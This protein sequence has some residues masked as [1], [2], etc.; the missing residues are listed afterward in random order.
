MTGNNPSDATVSEAI[1][2]NRD[3]ARLA[4]WKAIEAITIGNKW[5]DKLI[6]DNLTEAGVYLAMT[7][8]REQPV[9]NEGWKPIAS[10]ADKYA[11]LFLIAAPEL[12]HGDWNPEGVNIG[13]WQDDEGWRSTAWNGSQDYTYDVIVNPTHFQRIKGPYSPEEL[14]KHDE[15]EPQTVDNFRA[16]APKEPTHD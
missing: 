6:I 10:M 2:L 16:A 11:G 8:A 12:V 9:G 3:E 14:A 7:S 5:D 15:I 1:F 13:W 4:L